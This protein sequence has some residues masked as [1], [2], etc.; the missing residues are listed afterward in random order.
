MKVFRNRED[1][2]RF[3]LSFFVILGAVIGSLFCNG[4]SAEMKKE[5]CVTEQDLVSRTAL[6]GMDFLELF[7]LILPSRLWQLAVLLL[8]SLT[9][10][11]PLFLMVAAGYLG[12]SSSVMISSMTM[13]AGFFGL[14]H[15][16]LLVF[17]QC[18]FYVPVL[19]ILFW[20]MPM[21]RRRLTVLAALL[22][23]GMVFIGALM[24]A[25][26]NPWILMFF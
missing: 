23:V 26:I 6:A 17:P 22:L 13:S 16:F 3:G 21:E 2:L 1:S 5:L 19:Y 9:S 11:A 20:W 18:L 24:E 4:M 12:F 14:C 25:Y 7:F 8:I 10:L 15:C